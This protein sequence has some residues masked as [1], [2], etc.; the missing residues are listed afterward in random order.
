MRAK[1]LNT[2]SAIVI[3]LVITLSAYGILTH[4]YPKKYSEYVEKYAAEY[5]I[6]KELVYAI[7][8][9]ESNFRQDSVSHASAIGL[10]QITQSTFEWASQKFGDTEITSNSVYDPATNIK[11]GCCIYSLFYSEFG[12]VTTA[13]ACY[14]AGRG[15]VLKWLENKEYSDDGILLKSI[16]FKE[17]SEYVEKVQN[18]KKIYELLY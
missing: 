9:C 7:I 2:L 5:G 10:M 1:H 15:N 6:E 16:P 3:F 13:L 12:D 18:T 4:L 11:Y 17:T 8:K 14:N